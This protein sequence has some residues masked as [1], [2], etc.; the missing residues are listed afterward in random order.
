MNTA[1]LFFANTVLLARLFVLFKDDAVA[2]R[3]WLIKTVIEVAVLGFF[4]PSIASL[5]W[6]GGCRARSQSRRLALG[7]KGATEK[8]SWPSA[9]GTA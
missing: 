3:P 5:V 8:K 7:N 4:L 2:G 9:H 1:F 6:C